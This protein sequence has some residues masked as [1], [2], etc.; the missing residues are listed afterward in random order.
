MSAPNPS[1]H[2]VRLDLSEM[3]RGMAGKIPYPK[4]VWSPAG[5]WYCDPVEWKRNTAIVAGVWV[6]ILAF[7][8]KLSADNER[9]LHPPR[10][11]IP[12]QLWCKHAKDDD[13]DLE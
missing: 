11:K 8:F 5:G 12:S 2:P 7:T 3:G 4:W 6:V 9:R 10:W 13:P 1:S